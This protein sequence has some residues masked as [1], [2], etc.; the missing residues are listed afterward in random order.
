MLRSRRKHGCGHQAYRS[1]P[2]G[3]L[4]H[5]GI[6]RRDA[7]PGQGRLAS[8]LGGPR[9]LAQ[10]NCMV[11]SIHFCRNCGEMLSAGEPGYEPGARS[12][13]DIQLTSSI[14]GG[15]QPMPAVA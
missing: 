1:D 13:R 3:D 10:P 9:P 14:A 15:S 7:W 6:L 2:R 4:R 12:G 11:G 5:V 8:R